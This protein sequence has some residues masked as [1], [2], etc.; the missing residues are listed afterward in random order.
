MK[1]LIVGLG[2]I[3]DAYK[4]TRHNIGFDVIDCLAKRWSVGYEAG[5]LADVAESTYR[6]R[7]V[8]DQTH[9]VNESKWTFSCSLDG[10]SHF[11]QSF[12]Y[13]R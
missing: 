5:K 10:E 11:R 1:Y 7:Q 12:S 2:N 6:G 3:G 9:Y 4:N 13:R 8:I